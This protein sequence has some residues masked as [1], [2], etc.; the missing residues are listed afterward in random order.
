MKSVPL[1]IA[2]AAALPAAV[3]CADPITEG[4]PLASL[5]L[6]FEDVDQDGKPLDA[7]ALTLRS[8][9]GWQTKPVE[10]LSV[11][12][13]AGFVTPLVSDYESFKNGVVQASQATRPRV[14]DPSTADI[15]QLYLDWNPTKGL[16][17]R[18][19]RQSLKLDN[20]RFVGNV[21][22]RQTMQVMDGA[23]LEAKDFLPRLTADVGMFKGVRQI[24]GLYQPAA[25]LVANVRY[26][27]T[28]SLN[29]VAYRYGVDWKRESLVATSARTVGL[30]LD[31]SIPLKD[32]WKLPLTIEYAKQD[33]EGRGAATIDASYRRLGVGVQHGATTVR[34]DQEVLGSNKGLSAFQT[35]L[36]TNHLFQGWAD[37]FLTTPASGID[38]RF[39]TVAHKI[40]PVQLAAEYHVFKA[41]RAF[42][43]LAG[44]SRDYGSELDVGAT[45]T[46]KAWQAKAEIARFNEGDPLGAA[47][48]ATTRKRDTTKLWLMLQYTL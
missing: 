39:A 42:S 7:Q 37:L 25:I 10:G 20:V 17:F 29:A 11:T 43:S 5:R 26:A 18:A 16:L 32:G 14:V 44:T 24:S 27:I 1:Y 9:V 34:I 33:P 12:A 36:G 35:P 47:L 45:W 40:G 6:R 31:G 46:H 41:D 19:G 30:R 8:L 2:L 23:L 48:T 28:P 4:K 15:N 13:Q 22:F 38:D 21:E 3:A